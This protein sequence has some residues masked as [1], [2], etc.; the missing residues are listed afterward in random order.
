MLVEGWQ[1][2]SSQ[3][4]AVLGSDGIANTDKDAGWLMSSTEATPHFE[5]E[6]YTVNRNSTH[7]SAVITDSQKSSSGPQDQTGV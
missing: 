1:R 3:D 4:L 6:I 2:N 7:I 5:N